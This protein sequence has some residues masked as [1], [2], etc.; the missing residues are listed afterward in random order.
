VDVCPLFQIGVR[1][2]SAEEAAFLKETRKVTT[3]FAE[4]VMDSRGDFLEELA[5]F[6]DGKHVFLTVDCDAFDPGIM[7]AVGT[8]EPGGLSWERALEIARAV[9]RDAMSVPAFDVVELAPIPGFRAPDFLA[10]KLVYKL[11]SYA[12]LGVPSG[13]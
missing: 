10:A 3:V 8:P 7:P 5:N 1:S 2:L 13:E 12:L 6:V 11:V 4:Q 9:C